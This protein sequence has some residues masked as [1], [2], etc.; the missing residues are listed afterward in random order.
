MQ[1]RDRWR[2]LQRAAQAFD[3]EFD[4]VA[5]EDRQAR[6]RAGGGKAVDFRDARRPR[7]R[8]RQCDKRIERTRIEWWRPWLHDEIGPRG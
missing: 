5:L 2:A 1:L 4:G 6:T 8:P 7:L 3:R